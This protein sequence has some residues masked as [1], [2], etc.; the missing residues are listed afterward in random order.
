MEY[1]LILSIDC[2]RSLKLPKPTSKKL[3]ITEKD[4]QAEY[5]YLGERWKNHKHRKYCGI[6]TQTGFDKL[7]DDMGLAMSETETMGMIGAPHLDYGWSPAF[8]F[9]NNDS[10]I[11]MS[12]YV[13]PLPSNDEERRYYTPDDKGWSQLKKDL[14]EKYKD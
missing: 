8:S 5:G 4:D 12:M 2:P 6:V 3:Y 9:D 11:M 1:S 13:C 7:V 14:L 10:D